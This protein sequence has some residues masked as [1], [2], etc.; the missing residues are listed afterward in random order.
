[1]SARMTKTASDLLMGT[2]PLDSHSFFFTFPF[3]STVVS[4][5]V[6]SFTL[7]KFSPGNLLVHRLEIFQ[8]EVKI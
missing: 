4:D 1:M 2:D 6:K 7:V 8:S 3:V 5:S